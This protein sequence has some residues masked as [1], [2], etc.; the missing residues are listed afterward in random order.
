MRSRLLVLPTVKEQVVIAVIE[1]DILGERSHISTNQ[2]RENS[3]VSLLI[4]LNFP[5]N[6]VLYRS[7]GTFL[8]FGHFTGESDVLKLLCVLF[9]P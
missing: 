6:T 7:R 4:G 9:L 1:C 3:A 2:R 5:E 8:S